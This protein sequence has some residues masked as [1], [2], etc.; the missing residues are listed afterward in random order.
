MRLNF[1]AARNGLKRAAIRIGLEAVALSP[2]G[3]F[4]PQAAG[5]G[6]IF[7]LHHVRPARADLFDANAH[8]SVTPEFLD[9]AIAVCRT[10]GFV[11]V[12]LEA[13]PGLL[14]DPDDRRRFVSFTL[15]D[16]FRNNAEYAA[17]VFR[18]HEVPCTIFVTEGFVERTRSLWWETAAALVRDLST[19]RIDGATLDLNTRARKI[20]GFDRLTEL[21]LS[22]DEDSGVERL[23]RI[24]RAHGVDPL[25]ITAD[26]TMSAEEL[27]RLAR[28]PLV[29]I[30]A[31]T[32]THVNL[33]RVD[34]KRLRAE[35]AG[36]AAAV[37][38]YAG[39][40][41]LAFAY[42][43]GFAAAVGAREIQAVAEAGFKI[44]VTTQ[45][46]VLQPADVEQPTAF[47]RVSLSGLYQKRRHVRS[48][49]SGIP[50][51]LM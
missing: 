24:A 12:A 6:V 14:A 13:L 40:R 29:R 19:L 30:G 32:L 22:T 4:W 11:P 10:S 37:Q 50:F 17:P 51:R 7:T 39:Y 42:P 36:S 25:A 27:R 33:R 43:Y 16:G 9:Q 35:I 48:L 46:G 45:P 47:H 28:D 5:R 2:A 1:S 23:D 20:A 18:K 41:P 34:E 21:V 31:H 49:L 3:A 8:L 15:D 38:R 44:A 26:L